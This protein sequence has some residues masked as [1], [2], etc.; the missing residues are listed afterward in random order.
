MSKKYDLKQV[1]HIYKPEA[2]LWT[3]ISKFW[4][5]RIQ[6]TRIL[7]VSGETHTKRA[8]QWKITKI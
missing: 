5:K 8:S 2:D 7:F 4:S 6:E 3:D 1:G